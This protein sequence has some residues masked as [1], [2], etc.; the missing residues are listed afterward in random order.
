MAIIDRQLPFEYTITSR[1][2]NV[3]VMVHQPV[4]NINH[5]AFRSMFEISENNFNDWF[6]QLKMVLRVERKLF[7]IEEPISPVSPT[8]SEYLRS[9]M[10]Y[11]I[12]NEVACLMLGSM[13]PEL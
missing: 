6:R 4:Q 8:D 12:H 1:S 7:V 11:M 10:R 5:S 9:R 3:V 13:T 2:T